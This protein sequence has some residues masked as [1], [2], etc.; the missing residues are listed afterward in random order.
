MLSEG[1]VTVASANPPAL[2]A[3]VDSI[4]WAVPADWVA[5]ADILALVE[6]EQLLI[7]AGPVALKMDFPK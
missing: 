6:S 5:S 2:M 3:S 1:K 4:A 7:S